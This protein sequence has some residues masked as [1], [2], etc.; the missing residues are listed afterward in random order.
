MP[1]YVTDSLANPGFSRGANA[2]KRGDEP[3]FYLEIFPNGLKLW[4]LKY[5]IGGKKED[6]SWCL[7]RS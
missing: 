2:H 6:R 1:P 3:G 4:R 7:T 5:R